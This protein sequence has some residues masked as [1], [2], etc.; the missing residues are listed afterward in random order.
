MNLSNNHA[1]DRG[2]GGLADS[3]R[4]LRDAGIA[5]F[6]AGM[7]LGAAA[8]PLLIH[9]PFGAVAVV[10]ISERWTYG[11]VAG[12]HKPGTVSLARAAIVREKALAKSAGARWVVAFVHWGKNYAPITDKQRRF[13]ALLPRLATTL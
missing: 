9:T 10:G 4:H 12:P 3:M 6:G 8:A 1:L 7:D 13:A 11:S 2:P 5:P